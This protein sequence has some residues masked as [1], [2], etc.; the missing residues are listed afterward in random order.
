MNTYLTKQAGQESG[1]PFFRNDFQEHGKDTKKAE[2]VDK[3]REAPVMERLSYALVKVSSSSCEPRC[4]GTLAVNI[5]IGTYPQI[6]SM[7][8]VY[9]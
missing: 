9:A 7:S 3:W 2:Q 4:R 6:P 1:Y 8:H 5:Q